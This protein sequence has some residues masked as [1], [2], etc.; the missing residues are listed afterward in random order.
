MNYE[1]NFILFADFLADVEDKPSPP[2]KPKA[3]SWAALLGKKS[4]SSANSTSGKQNRMAVFY[5]LQ[6]I[7]LIYVIFDLLFSGVCEI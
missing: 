7:S 6:Y 3:S 4:S 5:S 1:S 2:P